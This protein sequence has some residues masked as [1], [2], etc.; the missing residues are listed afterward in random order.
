MPDKIV[1]VDGVGQ[2]SFPDSMGDEDIAKV[3]KQQHPNLQP[4][5]DR[6]VSW[7]SATEVPQIM[8]G[9]A[10]RAISTAAS[11]LNPM[12]LFRSARHPFDTAK[13]LFNATSNAVGRTQQ[14]LGQGNYGE[15]AKSAL[16]A[17]P[18]VG[19]AA[20]TVAR[21]VTEGRIPEAVGHI[22]AAYLGS[23]LPKVISNIPQLP[24]KAMSM[25]PQTFNPVPHLGEAVAA[26]APDVAVGGLKT[27][28]GLGTAELAPGPLKWPVRAALAYPGVRQ[29]GRGFKAG[30]KAASGG[31]A[32]EA[33][34]ELP[35]GLPPVNPEAEMLNKIAQGFGYKNFEQAPEAVQGTIRNVSQGL[36]KSRVTPIRTTTPTEPLPRARQLA[37]APRSPIVTPPPADTSGIIPGWAPKIL[38]REAEPLPP[39]HQIAAP[40]PKAETLQIPAQGAK[41]VVERVE[42]PPFAKN[43]PFSPSRAARQQTPQPGTE[44]TQSLEQQVQRL[45]QAFPWE[46]DQQLRA[47]AG[48]ANVINKLSETPG[49][50]QAAKKLQKALGGK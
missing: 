12:N 7:S 44:A 50:M 47:R 39:S 42:H 2:V 41:E 40:L 19:P 20:E 27:A 11:D 35:T 22:G 8:A 34:A 21:D 17:V 13:T 24:E 14:A 28:A 18:V 48:H 1:Q 9:Q 37:A 10:G 31:T 46:T 38:R 23:K 33:L 6:P 15:A 4:I 5:G 30:A 3:I 32:E 16:G 45:K 43:Q 49:A 36:S 26:A 25:V 29:I